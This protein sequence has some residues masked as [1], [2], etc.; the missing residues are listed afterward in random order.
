MPEFAA[1]E[2]FID[3]GGVR[4][5][6]VDSGSGAPIVP[7]HAGSMGEPYA[8]ASADDWNLNIP[9]LAGTNRV[10]AVDRLGQG[11]T[12]NPQRDQDWSI[13]GSIAHLTAFLKEIDVGPCHLVGHSEGGYVAC[14]VT[15]N[16]PR[17]VASCT[18]VDSHTTATGAG[19]DEYILALN[20]H[21]PGTREAARTHYQHYSHSFDHITDDWLAANERVFASEGNREARRVMDE[22]GLRATI[23][24][25]DLLFDREALIGRLGRGGLSRPVMVMWGYDDPV[26]PIDQGHQL[27]R[28]LAQHQPRSQMHIINRAGHYAFRERVSDFNRALADFV[29]GVTDGD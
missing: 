16:D 28:L 14:R 15:L 11:L 21:A 23:Y 26:A 22:V 6:Y 12:G 18:I 20:K 17:L 24:L 29:Q 1:G 19:R 27:Y 3:V 5:R 4:T 2:K 8:A 9:G 25:N 13:T 10:I 7:V